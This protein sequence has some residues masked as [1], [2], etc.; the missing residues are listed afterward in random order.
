VVS[1]V[2]CGS[3]FGVHQE[4]QEVL[5]VVQ[6]DDMDSVLVDSVVVVAAYRQKRG[7]QSQTL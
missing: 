2:C 1:E 7:Q 4:Q 3:V 5:A 6:A